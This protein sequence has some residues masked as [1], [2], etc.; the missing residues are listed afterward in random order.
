MIRLD[1]KNWIKTGIEFVRGNQNVS[2]VVTRNFSDWSVLPRTDNPASIWIRIQRFNETVQISYSLDGQKWSMIRP[3]YFPAQV[4]VKIGM[5]TAASGKK[6]FELTSMTSRLCRSMRLL[7][8]PDD[9]L[10]SWESLEPD[11]MLHPFRVN[12]GSN[13]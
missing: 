9:V 7:E 1:E 8:G 6:S 13:L 2:A 4:P 5:V 3:A 11:R 12:A 10:A